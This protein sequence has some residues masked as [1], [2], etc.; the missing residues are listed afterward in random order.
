MG[1]TKEEKE[2]KYLE[3][4]PKISAILDGTILLTFHDSTPVRKELIKL[5]KEIERLRAKSKQLEGNFSHFHVDNQMNDD[6]ALC[7]LGTADVVHL[8]SR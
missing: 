1:A 5:L 3:G 8:R 6:C 7:G 2:M 4:Y